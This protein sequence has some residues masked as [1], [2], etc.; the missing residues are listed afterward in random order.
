MSFENL[1]PESLLGDSDVVD[2]AQDMRDRLALAT[3]YLANWYRATKG[4]DNQGVWWQRIDTERTR[5]EAAYSELTK[6]ENTYFA[7]RKAKALYNDAARDFPQLWRDLTL[8]ADTLPEP[9]LLNQ[10][11]DL[12]TTIW[13]TPSAIVSDIGNEIGKAIGGALGNLWRQAWPWLLVGGAAYGVYVFRAP[14]AA[15]LKGIK[16]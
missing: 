5:V 15:A 10:A 2:T 13:H 3:R 7:S 8:S 9:S 4:S 1:G 11:A 14:I 16:T 6:N 12:A